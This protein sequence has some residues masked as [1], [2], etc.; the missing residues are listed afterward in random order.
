M[1]HINKKSTFHNTLRNAV[2]VLTD[3][4][5]FDNTSKLRCIALQEHKHFPLKVIMY[6]RILL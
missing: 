2:I 4:M 3:D 6:N 1:Q 5:Q